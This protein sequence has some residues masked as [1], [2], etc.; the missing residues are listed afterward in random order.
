[1]LLPVRASAFWAAIVLPF[2]S[3][4][5]M[6]TGHVASASSFGSVLAANV[7]AF[8]VGHGYRL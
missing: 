1:L 7:A 3:L 8:V 5:L 6:A 4:A 2:V